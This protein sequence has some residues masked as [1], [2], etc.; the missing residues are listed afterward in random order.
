[1]ATQH[2]KKFRFP[3]NLRFI[4]EVFKA[5]MKRGESYFSSRKKKMV[6]VG[7]IV[8]FFAIYSI[9]LATIVGVGVIVHRDLQMKKITDAK[10]QVLL[11][12]MQYWQRV[13]STHSD[14]RDGYFSLAV[15]A[16]QLGNTQQAVNYAEKALLLDPNF[17]DARKLERLLVNR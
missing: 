7:S 10:Q 16:Y 9:L 15:V 17:D 6:Y 3:H 11:Q 1:M 14:Y 4:T 8:G 5:S 2:L 13:V 12:K